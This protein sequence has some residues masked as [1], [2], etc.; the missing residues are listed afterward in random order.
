MAKR[1]TDTE[2]WDKEWF[3]NLSL[4]HK[5]LIRFLFDKCDNAGVWSANWVLASQYIGEQVSASDLEVL[6]ERVYNFAPGKFYVLDFIEFQYG[7]L[8]EKCIP[9]KK[10]ISLLEKYGL[11]NYQ[12][13]GYTKPIHTLKEEEEDK[14]ED[15]EKTEGGSGETSE[16]SKKILQDFGFTETANFD[17]LR[18][19]SAAVREIISEGRI[20]YFSQQYRD[21]MMYKHLANEKKHNL[22][23]FFGDPPGWDSANWSKKIQDHAPPGKEGKIL[24]NIKKANA[25]VNPFE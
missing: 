21:Y 23:T 19:I 7:T 24:S 25:V 4:K 20:D 10:I 11:Q 3:M 5:C 6:S 8:S 14:E 16:I 2:L 17:K 15:R 1:F 18:L 22:Q 9:H 12:N 13:V